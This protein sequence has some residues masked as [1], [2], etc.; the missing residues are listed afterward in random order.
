MNKGEQFEAIILKALVNRE[1]KKDSTPWNKGSDIEELKASVKYLDATI[2]T[3]NIHKAS[4][5]ATEAD[6]TDLINYYIE[7]VASELFIIGLD[8]ESYYKLDKEQMREY[9]I[10][11]A[12][13]SNASRSKKEK[14]E[15]KK[16]KLVIRIRNKSKS[17]QLEHKQYF[18]SKQIER[19]IL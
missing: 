1:Y 10:N 18:E 2:L 15:D 4:Q 9:L 8:T 12:T 6:R 11:K 7:N 3:S 5:E 14:E 13:L 17:K 16:G 19:R